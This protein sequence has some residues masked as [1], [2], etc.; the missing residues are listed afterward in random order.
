MSRKF[1]ATI[2]AAS[3]AVTTFT[4]PAKAGNDDLVKFLAGATALVIIGTAIEQSNRGR[5]TTRYENRYVPPK[6]HN[7]GHRDDRYDNRHDSRN[8]RR[9][10]DTARTMPSTCRTTIN[11]R[12]GPV[13]AFGYSCVQKHPRVAANLPGRC[14]TNAHTRRG[15]Q[16][17]YSGQCLQGAGIRTR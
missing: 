3:L 8:D 17:V 16:M 5:T 1:I 2:L 4:A 11:T 6:A 12:R 7:S 10:R 15:T 9:G 14:V 13:E